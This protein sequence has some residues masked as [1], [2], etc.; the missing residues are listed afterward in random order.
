[1]N[2]VD[3]TSDLNRPVSSATQTALDLKANLLN[4][5]FSGVLFFTGSRIDI[6]PVA[7]SNATI[8]L[9]SDAGRYTINAQHTL[10]ELSSL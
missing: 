10:R 8:Q 4:P 1:M 2:L 7:G 6:E 9:H 3:N 5:S